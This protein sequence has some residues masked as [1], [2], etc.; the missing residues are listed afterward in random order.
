MKS[1]ARLEIISPRRIATWLP[2]IECQRKSSRHDPGQASRS[3]HELPRNPTRRSAMSRNKAL[4]ENLETRR[5]YS[6][7]PLASATAFQPDTVFHVNLEPGA[8]NVKITQ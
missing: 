1:C 4:I 5:L 8:N 2:K 3:R 6:G 7:S